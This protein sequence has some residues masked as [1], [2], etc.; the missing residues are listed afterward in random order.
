M[1]NKSSP[2]QSRIESSK[3]EQLK[4]IAERKGFTVSMLIRII[5][6]EYLET[7]NV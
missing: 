1:S 2:L 6:T 3:T 5:I 7:H 4:K